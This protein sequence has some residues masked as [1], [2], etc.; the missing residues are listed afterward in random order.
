MAQVGAV[1]ACGLLAVAS[2]A[3]AESKTWDL[4]SDFPLTKLNPAPDKYGHTA[5]WYYM[6]RNVKKPGSF[7]KLSQFYDAAEEEAACGLKEFYLWNKTKAN[8]Q[9]TPAIFYNAGETVEP[10]PANHCDPAATYPGKTVFMHPQFSGGGDATVRWVAKASGSVSVSGTVQC[11]D[12]FVTGISWQLDQGSTP[13]LGPAEVHDDTLR[14]F[15]P[16][17][18]TVTRGQ[19]LYFIVGRA[20]E[21]NGASDTTAVSLTITSP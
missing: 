4:A 3:R 13:I 9:A 11:V 12:P 20:A 16:L 5:V 6:Y 1:V 10:S 14:S 8:P 18:V 7:V 19:S 17:A 21:A 15:G 2:G